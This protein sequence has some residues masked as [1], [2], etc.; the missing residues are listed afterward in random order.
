LDCDENFYT[1][2]LIKGEQKWFVIRSMDT[3]WLVTY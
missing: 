2:E 3:K 1:I